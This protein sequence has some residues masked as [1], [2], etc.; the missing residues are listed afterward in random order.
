MAKQSRGTTRT[1]NRPA[2]PSASSGSGSASKSNSTWQPNKVSGGKKS[3]GPNRTLLY[4]IGGIAVGLVIVIL[5]AV[6]QLGSNKPTT[7]N[8]PIVTPGGAWAIPASIPSDGRTLGN[9]DAKATIDL[10]GDFRCSACYSFT[11]GGIST[12]I[13]SQLVATGKAKIVWHDYTVIDMADKATASRDAANAAI[14]A[15]DQGKFWLMHD[16]LYAN[17]SMTEAPSAFTLD[18]LVKIAT[19]AGLDMTKAE[20]CIRNGT[21]NADIA[22]EESNIPKEVTGTPTVFVNGALVKTS[23]DAIKAAVDAANG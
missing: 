4:T 12:Q 23:F 16:W 8:D 6:N 22:T 15:A 19:Q 3:G 10:W 21:H 11:T 14:C 20:P 13:T 2:A 1:Q 5:V 18:R 7:S 17:Q 9:A